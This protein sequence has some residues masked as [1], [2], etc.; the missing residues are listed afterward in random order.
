MLTTTKVYV[1]SRFANGG[2]SSSIEYEIPGGIELR[3]TARCW[4]SEFTCVASWDTV[5]SSNNKLTI[6]EQGS[7]YRPLL[8]ETGPQDLESLRLGLEVL[9]NGPTK[10]AAMGS[11]TVARVSSGTGGGT[12]RLFEVACSSGTFQILDSAL[13][14]FPTGQQQ[15]ASHISNF[16]DLRRVHSLFLHSPSFGAYNSVGPRGVRTILAKIPANVGYGTLV[17]YASSSSEHDYVECGVS[18]LN[19]LRLELRDA[20]G[21]L[22]DLNGTH[23]SATILFE[24]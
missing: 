7:V 11:Y 10:D 5:D 13:V 4:L 24:R 20:A 6:V 14:A 3:P 19:I 1:D 22:L 12:F 18:G 23:W 2:S 8:L 21:L 16:V 15:L 9:L 17:S